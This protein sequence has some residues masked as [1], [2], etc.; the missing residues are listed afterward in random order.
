M[1]AWIVILAVGLGTYLFRSVMFVVLGERELP[2]WTGQPMAL[3]GPAAIG[4][5]LG[6]ML[7]TDHGRFDPA[8]VGELAAA[9]L[10]FLVVRRGGTV[11]HGILVGFV[12]LWALAL[13]GAAV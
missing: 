7:L 12:T 8:G 11:L 13:I 4:A 3:V 1:T 10:A 5:L 9:V 2:A 6:G